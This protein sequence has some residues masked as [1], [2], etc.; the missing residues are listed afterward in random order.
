MS[1]RQWIFRQRPEGALAAE[2]FAWRVTPR[3]RAAPAEAQLARW[4]D[5]GKLKA[6]VHVFE[7]LENAPQALLGP[8]S[9]INLGKTIVRLA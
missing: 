3:P 6:P 9:G 8:L 2:H 4:L 7:G 5:E 1:N